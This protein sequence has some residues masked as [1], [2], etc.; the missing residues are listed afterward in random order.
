MEKPQ[1]NIANYGFGGIHNLIPTPLLLGLEEDETIK[2]GFAPCDLGADGKPLPNDN[3]GNFISLFEKYTSNDYLGI[4]EDPVSRY[5]IRCFETEKELD[6]YYK[7]NPSKANMG[8]FVFDKPK[9][10]L[11]LESEVAYTM[12]TNSSGFDLMENIYGGD[13]NTDHQIFNMVL[14]FKLSLQALFEDCLITFRTKQRPK[15]GF[16]VRMAPTTTHYEY[17]GADSNFENMTPMYLIMIISSIVCELLQDILAEKAA[18][19]KATMQVAGT[20]D[21]VYWAA[22]FKHM[23]VTILVPMSVIGLTCGV[24][25]FKASSVLVVLAFMVLAVTAFVSMTLCIS[26]FLFNPSFGS[27]IGTVCVWIMSIP[28]FVLDK[29]E[30][31]LWI[32]S[33]VLL[34]P[35][36]AYS[37]GLKLLSQ[38]ELLNYPLD[39]HGIGFSN[40]F[41]Q[42]EQNQAS[43]GLVMVFLIFDTFLLIGLAWYFEK[44]VPDQWGKCLPLNFIFQKD[45]WGSLPCASSEAKEKDLEMASALS[46]LKRKTDAEAKLYGNAVNENVVGLQTKR[47]RKVFGVDPDADKIG[48]DNKR[49]PYYCGEIAF[50]SDWLVEQ[51]EGVRKFVN[52]TAFEGTIYVMIFL[53]ILMII[54]DNERFHNNDEQVLQIIDILN[55]FFAFVFTL[56]M[57]WKMFGLSVDGYFRDPF[58]WFDFLLVVASYVEL[59]ILKGGASSAAKGAKGL[60]SARAAKLAKFARM[61]KMVRVLRIARLLRWFTH[62]DAKSKTTI[63]LRNLNLIAYQD[64]ILS[65]LGQNGAGKTTFF[66]MLMGILQ[67]T[68]GVCMV[69]GMDILVSRDIVKKTVGSCPQHDILFDYYTIEEHLIFYGILKGIHPNDIKGSVAHTLADVGLTAKKDE[70]VNALSGGMRRRTSIA[71]ACL[72]NPKIV[73]LDEPSAGVD[74]VN[75]QIVW[76]T[77]VELKKGRTII[78]STHFME[79]AEILGDR[80]AVLKKGTL[81]VVGSCTELH[82]KFGAGYILV[83]TR[84]IHGDKMCHEDALQEL[85]LSI[86]NY[87]KKAEQVMESEEA[88]KI[89]REVAQ[90][91]KDNLPP[92]K[93][94]VLKKSIAKA[95]Q[96]VEVSKIREI[97]QEKCDPKKILALL[98]T[99][100]PE[101]DI[102][103]FTPEQATFEFILPFDARS[104]FANMFEELEKCK[105]QFGFDQFGISAP[106]LQEVFLEIS[107]MNDDLTV[108]AA[109]GLNKERRNSNSAQKASIDYRKVRRNSLAQ[110]KDGPSAAPDP[111]ACQPKGGQT[112][113]PVVDLR[114]SSNSK[115]KARMSTRQSMT[116]GASFRAAVG[117]DDSGGLG[118]IGEDSEAADAEVPDIQQRN[119]EGSGDGNEESEENLSN[120]NMADV[121]KRRAS[122]RTSR[123][124]NTQKDRRTSRR[125]SLSNLA[126]NVY[127]AI[128]PK[129]RGQNQE[130]KRGQNR[131]YMSSTQ[132]YRKNK[133]IEWSPGAPYQS[134]YKQVKAMVVKRYIITKR[135]RLAMLMQGLLPIFIILMGVLVLTIN[136]ELPSGIYESTTMDLGANYGGEGLTLVTWDASSDKQSP[137]TN[138]SKQLLSDYDLQVW[139]DGDVEKFAKIETSA[140][141][142]QYFL[143][144]QSAREQDNGYPSRAKVKAVFPPFLGMMYTSSNAGF[145]QTD[146]ASHKVDLYYN[147]TNLK[148]LNGMLNLAYS[149]HQFDALKNLENITKLPNDRTTIGGKIKAKFQGL[150]MTEVEKDILS[151]PPNIGMFCGVLIFMSFASITASQ[152][153]DAVAERESG[154]KRQQLISGVNPIAYWLSNLI[155]DVSFYLAVPFGLTVGIAVVFNVEPFSINLKQFLTLLGYWGLA[156]P[157]FSYACSFVFAKANSAQQVMITFNCI[158]S[159]LIIISVLLLE[160][161]NLTVLATPLRFM[162]MMTPQICLGFGLWTFVKDGRLDGESEGIADDGM[163]P[164]Y[165]CISQFVI[166]SVLCVAMENNQD[167]AFKGYVESKIGTIDEAAADTCQPTGPTSRK[168]RKVV[169]GKYFATFIFSMIILNVVV[170]FVDMSQEDNDDLTFVLALAMLN[171]LFSFVFFAEMGMKIGATGPIGYCRDPFNIFD[172]LLVLLSIVE[173]FLSGKGTFNAAKSGKVVGKSGRMLKLLRLFKFARLLRLVRFVR[174]MEVAGYD[175]NSNQSNLL[176]NARETLLRVDKLR[177]ETGVRSSKRRDSI[178]KRLSILGGEYLEGSAVS[179]ERSRIVRRLSARNSMYSEQSAFSSEAEEDS[180]NLSPIVRKEKDDSVVVSDLVKTFQR[181]GSSPV[182]ATNDVT[183]GIRKGEIFSLL[184]PN[185]AGKSTLLNVMTGSLAPSSG[186]VYVLDKN[187]STQ[188]NQIKSKIGF[189]PQFDALVAYMNSYETL[190]MFARIKGIDEEYIEPLV[191][192]LIECIGLGPFAHKMSCQYSGG[193]KRKLS[194]AI[195]LLGNPDLVFLDEPSTGLDPSALTDVYSC[196]WMWTRVDPSRSIVLT[197]HSME[198]ADSLSNRIGILVNG[199]LAVL[200][201][202][203]DLKSNFGSNYTLESILRPGPDLHSRVE[204]LKELIVENCPG[205]QDD[206][207][208]DG[209]IRYELPQEELKLHSM[210]RLLE[211]KREELQIKDYTISQTTLEQV[212]IHFA[213]HQF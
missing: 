58:N 73:L 14:T 90:N 118:V 175:N 133:Q 126:S 82:N 121:Q 57:F 20:P 93:N 184:G 6:K 77:L 39:P 78:M 161:N 203:Q 138:H 128:S 43:L 205:S 154:C 69:N 59:I 55:F 94:P 81:Q 28:G 4:A 68:S 61:A 47:L 65:L 158:V 177:R 195:S 165:I 201:S 149:A 110:L 23:F 139:N 27:I 5:D 178:V 34:L 46:A 97:N 71:L 76:K 185:G 66:S 88:E 190:T 30:T 127:Q 32:K 210:F 38:M 29:K 141:L 206:G 196:V 22:W 179:L 3:V 115:V 79:E 130:K 85:E 145:G 95:A 176:S 45:Y 146:S 162:G 160:E 187:I 132:K 24:Y 189:C 174:F 119:S 209:R 208:F 172:G 11:E 202:S 148:S 122:R 112:D 83:I 137:I 147:G 60:K 173:I 40:L 204:T 99:F 131:N 96:E 129:N 169:A 152:C 198:E 180:G 70:H 72:G 111:K 200:G 199:K 91:W 144:S 63:A 157:T 12:R 74:I 194:V 53:N 42:Y 192:S 123:I 35:P 89:A 164:V 167:K 181:P 125:S 84:P 51:R 163:L 117:D 114:K 10:I 171:Y 36:C 168:L 87:V 151:V 193:N 48:D 80:V 156:S 31:A 41:T 25:I 104:T 52:S 140:Q 92:P 62:D 26:S 136:H 170:V 142:P 211:A 50:K 98:K 86:Q 9:Q 19:H 17:K 134:A 191:N 150:S 105:E 100:V 16:N 56:E 15:V 37:H 159:L 102:L 8:G 108:D 116:K 155:F 75:R 106:T 213:Q 67:P 13:H 33:F 18:K 101:A 7:K 188:F 166:C 54:F 182:T 103:D 109:Y 186:E 2:L 64:E 143:L 183:F 135:N 107:D 120:I 124:K 212:F 44:V 197:T 153:S 207:S 21:W 49:N 1:P 113:A